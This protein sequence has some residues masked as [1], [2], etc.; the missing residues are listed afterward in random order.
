[1]ARKYPQGSTY[2]KLHSLGQVVHQMPRAM[3][4]QR[5][6]AALTQGPTAPAPRAE[7]D[8]GD[9]VEVPAFYTV[10]IDIGG[11]PNS[12]GAGSVAL[13]PERF[14]CRRITYAAQADSPPYAD[15]GL[16]SVNA[17][18]LEVTWG[19]EFTQFLGSNPTLIG[20]LFGQANGFLDLPQGIL[21]QG[22]QSLNVKLRRLQWP[23][24]SD[25]QVTRVDITFHGVGLLPVN[26]GGV[27]GSL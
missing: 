6:G 11:D 18:C 16:G 20:A 10:T 13:R 5:L 23:A 27:S 15:I 26:S 7:P 1:M 21:F 19:D 14:E 22:R 24:A 9:F 2:R 3:P 12:Q 4:Q 25:P 8:P 17:N